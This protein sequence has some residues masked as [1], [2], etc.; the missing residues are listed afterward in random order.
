MSIT[1]IIFKGN[2]VLYIELENFQVT[3]FILVKNEK[4]WKNFG[5]LLLL[6]FENA[7]WKLKKIQTKLTLIKS[8]ENGLF[9]NKKKMLKCIKTMENQS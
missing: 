5:K 3:F 9:E 2:E 8:P 4:N 1:V 7:E 6:P